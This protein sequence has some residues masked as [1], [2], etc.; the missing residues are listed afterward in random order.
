M[1]TSARLRIAAICVA[2]LTSSLFAVPAPAEAA[3]L[4]CRASM[5]DSTPKQYTNVY[6][7][8][9]TAPG[10][11]VRTVAHYKTTNNTKRATANSAGRAS[12]KYYI[13]GASA[14][15]RVK[16]SITVTKNGHTRTCA[17]SF[18]PHR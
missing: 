13:S 2:T 18:V 14:G 8:V 10:A 1:P 9:R 17:T 12:I 15:Y 16:V 3:A 4:T 7:R 6:A 5:S 11:K